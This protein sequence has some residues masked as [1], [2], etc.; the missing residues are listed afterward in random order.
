MKKLVSLLLSGVLAVGLLAGCGG[1]TG[2]SGTADTPAANTESPAASTETGSLEGTTLK[3]G[4]TPAP[5]A[6]IL[7]VVKDILAEQGITLD[8][9]QYNDYVQPN[10]AVEDGSL[11]ANYF[12][13]ITY[14]NDFNDQN[15]THLVSAAEVHYE[16]MSLYAGKVSS[17]DEL[18]DGAL[19]GVPNDATNEAR[20]LLVLQQEGLITLRDG[21]GITATIN[22]IVDNPKNLQFSEMEAAQLPLRLADLDMAV[23][24]GNYAIDAGLSMDDALATESADGEAAQ[25]YVN[26]LA[27]KEGRETDPAIQALAAALCSDEVKTYIEESYNGAVV[28]VF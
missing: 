7:E 21:A 27:V 6:E 26:V 20:A 15:G 24:N 28:A 1:N 9:V 22:D 10:N 12:Q 5:H 11:D 19:I 4:A 14:M 25:A 8:I 17:L 16:P 3:V 18:A 13:H 2:S 23:I